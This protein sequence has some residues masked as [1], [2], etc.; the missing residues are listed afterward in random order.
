MLSEY[1]FK[2]IQEFSEVWKVLK[3]LSNVGL[4]ALDLLVL[5]WKWNHILLLKA[6]LNRSRM[7]NV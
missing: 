3:S 4:L 1:E 7:K 6:I 5:V 2:L